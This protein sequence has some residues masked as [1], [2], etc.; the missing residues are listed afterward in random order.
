MMPLICKTAK[1]ASALSWVAKMGIRTHPHFNSYKNIIV[2][3]GVCVYESCAS[4][5]I[6]AFPAT[7]ISAGWL[8]KLRSKQVSFE[9]RTGFGVRFWVLKNAKKAKTRM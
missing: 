6:R 3:K 1:Q 2:F 9:F 5:H 8:S 4:A 7:K